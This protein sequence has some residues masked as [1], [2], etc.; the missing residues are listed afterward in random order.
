MNKIE[1]KRQFMAHV[2]SLMDPRHRG[3]D[4][5]EAHARA[6]RARP[7]LRD[8]ALHVLPATQPQWDR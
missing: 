4:Y 1:R 6:C 7:D 5:F 3:R 2:R 8:D